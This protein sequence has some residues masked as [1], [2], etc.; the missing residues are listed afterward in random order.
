M[1]DYDDDD[2]SE[3]HAMMA[4]TDQVLDKLEELDLIRMIPTTDE[5][6]MVVWSTDFMLAALAFLRDFADCQSLPYI[7][8][9]IELSHQA[10]LG[11]WF[12]ATEQDDE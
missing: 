4:R 1:P 10:I 7:D 3:F 2:L 6:L 11:S 5:G 9:A 12:E 8:D